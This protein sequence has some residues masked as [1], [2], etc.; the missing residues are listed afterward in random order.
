MAAAQPESLRDANAMELLPSPGSAEQGGF[1][2]K[3]GR[4]SLSRPGSAGVP[5]RPGSAGVDNR[6]VE[7]DGFKRRA[8]APSSRESTPG[9]APAAADESDYAIDGH[10]SSD[11][12][13]FHQATGAEA[14]GE[15]SQADVLA[16]EQADDVLAIDDLEQQAP[17]PAGVDGL[18]PLLRGPSKESRPVLEAIAEVQALDAETVVET[19]AAAAAAAAA[20]ASKTEVAAAGASK[21]PD[22]G[23][24]A[25]EADSRSTP[26]PGASLAAR[27]SPG[28]VVPS[29][30]VV[31]SREYADVRI[32]GE[33]GLRGSG[34]GGCSGAERS[35]PG[36]DGED[37]VW[38]YAE[39]SESEET[40]ETLAAAWAERVNRSRPN[41]GSRG[42]LLPR[43]GSRAGLLSSQGSRQGS[44]SPGSP[45][46]RQ[47][48]PGG[49]K[50]RV[51]R[52]PDSWKLPKESCEPTRTERLLESSVCGLFSAAGHP[53]RAFF[54]SKALVGNAS[55]DSALGFYLR[56]LI[57]GANTLLGVL[58]GLAPLL[59]LGS[60]KAIFQCVA[61][62]S[63]QLGLA[64]V[65]LGTPAFRE[66]FAGVLIGTGY[67]IEAIVT[68][69]MILHTYIETVEIDAFIPAMAA[70]ALPVLS[71]WWES[72]LA[73]WLKPCLA[74]C[75]RIFARRPKQG[76]AYHVRGSPSARQLSF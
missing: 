54:C 36:A 64:V 76:A 42:G 45:G 6:W 20:A 47:S 12:V 66:P 67:M 22:E 57:V 15:S 40:I 7:I 70:L 4:S 41:T 9:W 60:S 38:D 5:M 68:F 29:L 8:Q 34:A 11:T 1:D 21:K 55:W 61:V 18:L 31:P 65:V 59:P 27:G 46:S 71:M 62:L 23:V 43:P 10:E 52:T 33:N 56:P 49:F 28:V 69:L 25:W 13:D 19:G 26:S 75:M 24:R 53:D 63:V 39:E 58:S 44:R 35:A 51:P 37:V 72:L 73:P 3:V 48:S 74:K 14:V 30:A 50:Q 17:A 32:F 2:R 16:I